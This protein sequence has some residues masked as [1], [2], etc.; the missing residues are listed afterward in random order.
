MQADRILAYA[1]CQ[2]ASSFI[3]HTLRVAF[4]RWAIPKQEILSWAFLKKVAKLHWCITVAR[5]TFMLWRVH[6]V[7]RLKTIEKA[8]GIQ[9]KKIYKN[10]H[11]GF[12]SNFIFFYTSS[13][14]LK[15]KSWSATKLRSVFWH[16]MSKAF[17]TC[18]VVSKHNIHYIL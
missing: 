17:L 7:G 13:K 10:E 2:S 16:A 3:H 18:R 6:E 1:V 15:M 14:S 8:S 11:P 4:V 12:S 9:K 5:H